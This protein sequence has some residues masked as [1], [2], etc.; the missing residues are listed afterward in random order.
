MR[1]LTARV[2]LADSE[3]ATPR[4]RM[5]NQ[6]PSRSGHQLRSPYWGDRRTGAPTTSDKPR[7]ESLGIATRICAKKD[8]SSTLALTTE[9]EASPAQRQ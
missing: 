1:R 7:C 6:A 3:L 8:S 4:L 5:L 9:G 2:R